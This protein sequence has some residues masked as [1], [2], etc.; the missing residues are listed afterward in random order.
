MKTRYLLVTI[1]SIIIVSCNK[2][3]D[4]VPESTEVFIDGEYLCPYSSS[5]MNT[6][7]GYVLTFQK[8]IK[9]ITIR[10]NDTITGTYNI[11]SQSLKSA[12]TLQANILYYNGE[13]EYKG[14]DGTLKITKKEGDMI[15][16][17]YNS[18]VISNNGSSINLESGS[19]IDLPAVSLLP[20][21]SGISTML[22]TCYTKLFDYVEF[23]Y[24]FDAVYSNE[25]S[26]PNGSWAEI[27]NHALTSSTQN[28]K[29]LNLWTNGFELIYKINLILESTKYSTIDEADRTT[30]NAQAKA[31]RA[32][33]FYNLMIW[34]GEI[35]IEMG[36]DESTNPRN[37]IAETVAQI[38]E[39]AS[40]A[41]L[42]LPLQWSNPDNF[43]IPK[44]FALGILARLNLTDFRWPIS[45][46][47]HSTP[48]IY[49]YNNCNESVLNAQQIINCGIYSLD[50]KTTNF[51]VSDREI[52]WGFEKRANAEF[53][54]FFNKGSFVPVL[55][56]T[57][58]YLILAEALIQTGNPQEAIPIINLLND[59][60]SIAPVTA[61]TPNEIF[62]QWRTE[63]TPEGSLWITKR[64]F[65]DKAINV[66]QND[67]KKIL[68]PVPQ[69]VLIK[70]PN[71]TQN[72][73]Y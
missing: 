47:I 64:R 44:S 6:G 32:Y 39:D 4:L 36:I 50:N 38:K 60:R 16:G 8:G 29:V 21:V 70:N 28:E 66:V 2:Q 62:Q 73:G 31:I 54:N 7:G 48:S 61:A 26:A 27:Y 3:D 42:A 10:T 24:L 33:L 18:N 17:I 14:N 45:Y 65:F 69:S 13:T 20:T 41:A 30:I 52:I 5:A 56:L 57:E 1:L 22:E 49:L 9:K 37:T 59:R 40:S 53:N 72:V 25:V 55:R 11:V 46:E 34:F 58:V 19:F 71:L 35:P 23:L 67:P 51:S 43:R 15:A 12:S 63:L 68:L